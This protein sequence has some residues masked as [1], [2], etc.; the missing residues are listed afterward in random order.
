MLRVAANRGVFVRAV[1]VLWIALG[2]AMGFVQASHSHSEDWAT[3]Q[4]ACSSCSTAHVGLNAAP[5]A[6]AQ[7]LVTTAVASPAAEV[8]P[9]FRPVTTEFIRPPPAL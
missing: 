2:C 3:S 6:S 9:I 8:S 5:A 4:P 7:V 1:C